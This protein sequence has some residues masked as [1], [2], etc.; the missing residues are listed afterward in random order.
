MGG[1]AT[2]VANDVV[3]HGG[4]RLIVGGGT[5][6][7]GGHAGGQY[8]R[9]DQQGPAGEGGG[10]RGVGVPAQ[11]GHHL[12]MPADHRGQPVLPGQPDRV[13]ELG[14][15]RH[16]VVVQADERGRAGIVAEHRVEPVEGLVGQVPAVLAGDQRVA[17]RQD[18]PGH[19]VHLVE[20]CLRAGGASVPAARPAADP[21]AE[22]PAAEG[23]PLVVVSRQ[24]QH[25]AWRGQDRARFLVLAGAAVVSD[26]PG[27]QDRVERRAPPAQAV[28]HRRARRARSGLPSR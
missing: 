12:G 22:Q 5:H 7:P 21:V 8:A 1:E 27:D 2:V 18:R 6:V 9:G 11:D 4:G 17:Q 23:V 25:R 15:Q 20:R 19:A 16:G 13:G 28:H 24:E 3:R 10:R 14:V 26:V